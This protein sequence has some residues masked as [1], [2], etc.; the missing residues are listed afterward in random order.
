[1]GSTESRE[2]S[3]ILRAAEA[4]EAANF[5]ALLPLVYDHLRRIAARQ[6]AGERDDHTLEPTAL[7][8]EAY[9]R[10]IG[11][12]PLAWTTKARFYGAAAEAMRRILVEHARARARFKRGGDRKRVGINLAD[13]VS[14]NDPE[15]FLAVDE[16]IRRLEEVDPRAGSIVRLRLFAGLGVAETAQALELPQRTV[17][18]DWAYARSFLFE[19]LQ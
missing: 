8:H 13:L 2:V 15:T 10:L 12:D 4:G 19:K 11:R 3:R 6:M 16:A 1:V 14:Q 9:M 18:R 7:V 5:D 17:E